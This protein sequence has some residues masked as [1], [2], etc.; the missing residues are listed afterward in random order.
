[1]RFTQVARYPITINGETVFIGTAND[2]NA[3]AKD[4]KGLPR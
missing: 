3:L 2:M 4:P 1:M